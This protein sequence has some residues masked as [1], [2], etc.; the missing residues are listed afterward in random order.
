MAYSIA[1]LDRLQSSAPFTF[2][3]SE[4]SYQLFNTHSNSYRNYSSI[5]RKNSNLWKLFLIFCQTLNRLSLRV[6]YLDD[7]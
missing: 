3:R 7:A 2:K 4:R 5:Q 1:I 6:H